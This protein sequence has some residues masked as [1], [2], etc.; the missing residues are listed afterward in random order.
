MRNK[1]F[2]IVGCLGLLSKQCAIEQIFAIT[3]LKSGVQRFNDYTSTGATGSLQMLFCTVWFS[4]GSK[5]LMLCPACF[6]SFVFGSMVLLDMI[7]IS[8]Y[9]C[10]G[11]DLYI[12]LSKTSLYSDIK[13]VDI[14]HDGRFI[15]SMFESEFETEQ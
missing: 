8:L 7:F 9:V 3:C 12:S 4:W 10:L 14:L 15:C 11:G 5:I 2:Q 13:H 6:F 1:H